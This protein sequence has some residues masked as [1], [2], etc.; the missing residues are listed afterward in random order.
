MRTAENPH[1]AAAAYVLDA[2]SDPERRRFER[3]RRGCEACAAEA[4]EFSEVT[5]RLAAGSA[6][7][8]PDGMR[9]QVLSL[10]GRT[11]QAPP[12]VISGLLGAPQPALIGRPRRGLGRW[13]RPALVAAVSLAVGGV[14]GAVVD[15]PQ[16]AVSPRSSA[17]AAVLTAPDAE[18]L[19]STVA[20]G[21]K[22]SLV[23]S[24]HEAALVF[25]AAGLA[26]LSHSQCYELWLIGRDSTVAAGVLPSPVQGMTGP[27]IVA[28]LT[29]SERLGL[30]VE[31]MP[32]A[33]R[34]TSPM[35]IDVT[36]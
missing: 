34:P 13:R 5:S 15:S 29:S 12:A 21:G 3:H 24:H 35:L 28:D 8:P 2:L 26:A 27:V 7:P 23:M 20:G 10:A 19:S 30:S 11:R 22:A 25:T 14:L 4:G 36:L 6:V 16:Q 1:G 17:V 33:S 32:G 18:M 31:S 9:T